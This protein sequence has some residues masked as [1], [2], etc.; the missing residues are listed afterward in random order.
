M[1]PKKKRRTITVEGQDYEYA[2]TGS[3]SIEK[4]VSKMTWNGNELVFDNSPNVGIAG[5][6]RCMPDELGEEIARRWNAAMEDTKKP[7]LEEIT[8]LR[9]EE[10][11]FASD[12][13]PL[14][15]WKVIRCDR[16]KNL[17][18]MSTASGCPA[19]ASHLPV[20]SE[21]KTIFTVPEGETGESEI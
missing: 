10:K 17:E 3:T 20:G 2:V 18:G 7:G 5:I 11:K 6:V 15:F 14:R 8:V 16:D 9:V 4:W 21:C 1:I 12:D 13:L 19:P